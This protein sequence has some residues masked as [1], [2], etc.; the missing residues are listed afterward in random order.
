MSICGSLNANLVKNMPEDAKNTDAPKKKVP[1]VKE[2]LGIFEILPEDVDTNLEEIIELT[3]E[4]IKKFNAIVEA[5]VSEEI[6]YG[7]KKIKARIVFPDNIEG[8]TQPI[9]D[10]ISTIKTVQRV[11]CAMVSNLKSD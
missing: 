3:K 7:L 2:L 9:E 8:G 10:A 1:K 5:W 11:E 6:A 4:A